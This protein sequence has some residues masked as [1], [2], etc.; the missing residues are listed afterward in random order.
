MPSGGGGGDQVIQKTTTDPWSGIQPNLT[1]IGSEAK[2][3]YDAGTG[4]T[5]YPG[6]TYVGPTTQELVGM[7]GMQNLA[8]QGNQLLP[9]LLN[10]AKSNISGGGL[11]AEQRGG[12]DPLKRIASG[13]DSISVVQ[14]MGYRQQTGVGGGNQIPMGG[15]PDQ[16]PGAGAGEPGDYSGGGNPYLMAALDISADRAKSG[17]ET[18]FGG[19]GRG[20]GGG[21]PTGV[22]GRELGNLY[23]TGLSNQMN[24]DLDRRMAAEGANIANRAGA[25]SQLQNI[26]GQGANNALAWGGMSGDIREQQFGDA[27]KLID[28]G[29]AQR[30]EL[31]TELQSYID[32]FNAQQ[33]R[34]WDQLSLYNNTVSGLGG[35]SGTQTVTGQKGSP[36]A[37]ILGGGA[38]G[39]GLLGQLLGFL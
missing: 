33:S 34:P 5:Y 11:S 26:Y 2:K 19:M 4:P 7:Q 37:G 30:G 15:M 9:G 29:A 18:S 8:T 10:T 14:P 28:V 13:Q 24:A 22:I 31:Q 17:M 12:L 20:G 36:L 39:A 1:Q 23:T 25:A 27:G 21:Q 16:L 32:R 38:V 35:G 3:L 6:A